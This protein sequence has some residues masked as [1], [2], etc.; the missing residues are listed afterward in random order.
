MFGAFRPTAAVSG[1]LLWSVY[2]TPHFEILLL[3]NL[4]FQESAMATVCYAKGQRP[5]P[6]EE[7]GRGHRC[8]Q[9]QWCSVHG[10]GMSSSSRCQILE[11]QTLVA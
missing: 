3:L 8:R 9:S 4:Y 7:G 2:A 1:G 10:A 5:R 6:S 11:S